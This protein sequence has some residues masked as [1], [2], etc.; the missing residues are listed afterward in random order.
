MQN[1]RAV[2]LDR[3]GT[4]IK[5]VEYL[6]RLQD[7]RFLPKAKEAIKLLNK[8]NIPTVVITNQPVIAK[9]LLTERGVIKIHQRI[10]EILKKAGAKIDMFYFCPHHPNAALVKY[11][12][13]CECRKPSIGLF[14]E[15][16]KRFNIIAQQSYMIGDSFRD[17]E[18]GKNFG[19]KTIGVKCGISEFQQSI[20]NF[21]SENL[22]EAVKLIL[23]KGNFL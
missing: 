9:G 7:L 13:I 23:G 19:C 14:K 2:F 1:Q 18:A 4:I 6:Y 3:D 10:Q 16:A 5:H 21:W 20:P 12:L 8:F 22:Y 15:A 17:V 11:R